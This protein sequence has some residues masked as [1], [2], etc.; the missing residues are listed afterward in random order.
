MKRLFIISFLLQFACS[1]ATDPNIK[2][3]K[4]QAAKVTI[5]RDEWGVP[6]VFGKTDADVVFGVMYAQCERV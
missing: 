3:Y 5:V 6:H 4:K 2:R 1:Q